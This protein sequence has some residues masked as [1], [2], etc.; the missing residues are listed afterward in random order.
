MDKEALSDFNEIPIPDEV[1]EQ[2][3]N[4]AATILYNGMIHPFIDFH[5]KGAIWYQGESN[6]MKTAQYKALFPAL[7]E[8]W[9]GLWNQGSFPFYFVQISPFAY[10]SPDDT[11]HAT[12]GKYRDGRNSGYW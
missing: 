9:R 6:R 11:K 2:R 8:S 4:H 10:G 7:I 3:P 1:P 12:C 5:I